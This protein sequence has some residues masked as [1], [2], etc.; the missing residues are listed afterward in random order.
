M[1][2]INVY[3]Q[4]FAAEGTFGGVTRRG[5]LVMLTADSSAGN[6]RYDA[7]VTFFPHRDEEDYAVSY[8]AYFSETLYEA[9]GRRS[10]KR[11]KQFLEDF[12]AHIDALAEAHGAAVCWDRPL[13]EPRL[14]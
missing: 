10:K 13:T 3:E 14:G 2:V 8:D 1:A 7:A 6:I 11:E 5:A 12:R 9:P 4:Y